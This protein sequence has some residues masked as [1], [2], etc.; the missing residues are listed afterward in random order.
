MGTNRPLISVVI[1]NW[2]GMAFLHDCLSSL[3]SQSYPNYEIVFVDNASTDGSV[4]YVKRNFPKV[5]VFKLNQNLEFAGGNNYGFK[6][7]NGQFVIALNADTK[8]PFDF[9]EKMV[10]P[11]LSDCRIG[12]V[13]CNI[14]TQGSLTRYCAVRFDGQ[15]IT[16]IEERMMSHEIFIL[17][18]CGAAA[19]YRKS[20]IDEYWGYDEEFVTNWEDHSIGYRIWVLGYYCVHTPK[21]VIDHIGGGAYGKFNAKRE[22]KVIQNKLA[23]YYLNKEKS[24]SSFILKEFLSEVRRF[25]PESPILTI[26]I[27]IGYI[28]LWYKIRK[29][30]NIVQQNRKFSDDLIHQFTDGYTLWKMDSILIF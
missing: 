19:L 6:V 20:I 21:V 5:R 22:K 26:K 4:E 17:A 25:L 10:E 7:S 14:N 29:K 3:S 28:R 15:R 1:V 30:R 2:N 27:L 18:A 8:V 11:A 12:S 13:S 24:V 16:G 9:I 23:T